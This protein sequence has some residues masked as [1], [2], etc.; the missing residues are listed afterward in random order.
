MFYQILST[1]LQSELHHVRGPQQNKDCKKTETEVEP[2]FPQE[3]SS[4]ES[5]VIIFRQNKLAENVHHLL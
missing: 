1:T 5:F 3:S 4:D 2:P